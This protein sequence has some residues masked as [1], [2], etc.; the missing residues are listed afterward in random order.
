MLIAKLYIR[1]IYVIAFLFIHSVCAIHNKNSTIDLTEFDLVDNDYVIQQTKGLNFITIVQPTYTVNGTPLIING[2]SSKPYCEVRLT[3]NTTVIAMVITDDKGDWSYI[4]SQLPNGNYTIKADLLDTPWNILAEDV[5]SFTV[6]NPE[7]IIISSPGECECTCIVPG[8]SKITGIASLVSALVRISIDD[9]ITNTL[10]VNLDGNWQVSYPPL[11]NGSHVLLAELLTGTTVA[12][13]TVNFMSVNPIMFPNNICQ[14]NLIEGIIDISAGSG[15][16]NG[17]TYTISGSNIT[18]NFIRPFSVSPFIIA[19]G[20]YSSGTSTVTLS[21]VSTN[22][23]VINFST[24]TEYVH[25]MAS[26]LC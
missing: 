12:T 4:Y 24:G 6:V 11:Y 16:G 26:E 8:Y 9:V 10:S 5:H 22:E 14:I 1:I 15:S 13:D 20:Q 3:I 18:I 25:F 21:S 23:A 19:T 7:S 17:F 2:N